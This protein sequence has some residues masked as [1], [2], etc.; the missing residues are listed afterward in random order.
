MFDNLPRNKIVFLEFVF[1]H[2]LFKER[3]ETKELSLQSLLIKNKIIEIIEI[4]I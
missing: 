2:F 1:F 4:L 3:Q